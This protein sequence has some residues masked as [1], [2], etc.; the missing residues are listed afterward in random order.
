M[1]EN[2]INVTDI[3]HVFSRSPNKILKNQRKMVLQAFGFSQQRETIALDDDDFWVVRNLSFSVARGEA[4]GVLGRNGSGKSTLLR[5]LSG[6]LKA[7]EGQL[8]C[9]GNILSLIELG[10][11]FKAHLTGRE[12][13]YHRGSLLGFRRGFID[14]ICENVINFAELE[15]CIDAPFSTY[16]SGMK[17]RLA[18]AINVFSEPDILLIDEVLSVG[19]FAFKQ[20]CLHYI[21]SIKSTIAMVL[22]THSL[23]DVRNFCGRVL[24]FDD[25]KHLFFDNV[26]EGIKYYEQ[27]QKSSLK[28]HEKEN[29]KK[30]RFEEY[31]SPKSDVG[32]IFIDED[33]I[34]NIEVRWGATQL[35]EPKLASWQD[36][37]TLSVSFTCLID[38]QNLYIGIPFYDKN[39][40][41]LFCLESRPEGCALPQ[42][43]GRKEI[44]I[45]IPKISLLGG[46]YQGVISI[47]EGGY[48]LARVRIPDL[49]INSTAHTKRHGTV[50]LENKWEIF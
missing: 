49:I 18:F 5:I 7:N 29:M 38:V 26:D 25:G 21:Q 47:H 12:N 36:D 14:E 11:G 4:V 34:K 24:V 23:A 45:S 2:L 22:V 20:K 31:H 37:L 8:E 15:H 40:E 44:S 46:R 43:A 9:Y 30:H 1:K 35:G 17:M 42:G 16:S 41:Q 39:S 28:L 27:S 3:G 33:K 32:D 50:V 13:I 6:G 48:Y 10:K 19:D